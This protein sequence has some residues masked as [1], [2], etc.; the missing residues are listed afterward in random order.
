M[1]KVYFS[2]EISSESILRL[3]NMIADEVS[4]RIGIKLHFGE[5]GNRYFL[6]AGLTRDLVKATDA[7]F[8]E[9]N[10]LYLGKRRYTQSHIALAKEHGFDFAPIHILDEDGEFSEKREGYKHFSEVRL[11]AG[12]NDY[13]SL[14]IYSHFKGHLMAGFGG[15]VKNVGMGLASIPGKMAQHASAIPSV[16]QENCVNC[17]NCVKSCPGNAITLEPVVISEEKCIG[18]GKCIGACPQRVFSIPWNSTSNRIFQQRLVE[19]AKMIS[20]NR[21]FYYINVIDQVSALC[22]C[23]SSAPKPFVN[24][25]GVLASRDMLA[26]DKASFDLVNEATGE[27]DSFLKHSKTSGRYQLEYGVEIGL[28]NIDYE[29]IDIDKKIN[30]YNSIS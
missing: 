7:D 4:G 24:N 20:E 17:G 12:I 18:C 3:Y 28:G 1:E 15:A 21:N 22:D 29:L 30:E 10:V 2:R 13:S 16:N 19:Y 9:T 8:V 14:I 27:K 23:D 25:I 6:P 26:I 11:P 5:K